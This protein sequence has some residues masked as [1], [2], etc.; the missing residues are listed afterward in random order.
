MHARIY[1]WSDNGQ[2]YANYKNALTLH[3][4]RSATFALITPPSA[5]GMSTSHGSVRK[6]GPLK[7]GPPPS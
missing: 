1:I 7:M 6:F 5:A 2:I 3:C 4:R